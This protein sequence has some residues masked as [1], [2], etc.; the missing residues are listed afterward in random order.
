MPS[1]DPGFGYRRPGAF[2]FCLSL[3]GSNLQENRLLR[4]GESFREGRLVALHRGADFPLEHGL[5]RIA[6]P[7]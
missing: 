2:T 7:L 4:L 1:N 6:R 3:A 5:H